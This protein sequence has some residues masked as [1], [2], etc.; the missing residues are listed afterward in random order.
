M[1]ALFDAGLLG[2]CILWGGAALAGLRQM[3]LLSPG[4]LAAADAGLGLK[5]GVALPL[6]LA[7]PLLGLL[8]W[9]PQAWPGYHFF[10]MAP[11]SACISFTPTRW[12]Y[13][14]TDGC[15][16]CS[17]CTYSPCTSYLSAL[18]H[19]LFGQPMLA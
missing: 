19:L 1:G 12:R 13:T 9:W 18:L 4:L 6:G 11:N 5:N 3:G 14:A 15:A 10:P 16:I 8:I 7:L 17:F 2:F